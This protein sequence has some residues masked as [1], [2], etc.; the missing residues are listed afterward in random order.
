MQNP[1]LFWSSVSAIFRWRPQ[2]GQRDWNSTSL[3]LTIHALHWPPRGLMTP[4]YAVFGPD[5]LHSPLPFGIQARWQGSVGCAQSLPTTLISS[6]TLT[7][8]R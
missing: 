1:S 6:D 5:M 3:G 2:V 8:C 7:F 4:S